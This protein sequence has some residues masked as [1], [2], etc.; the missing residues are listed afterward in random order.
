MNGLTVTGGA[1]LI[2]QRLLVAGDAGGSRSI[3]RY[4]IEEAKR[5]DVRT[6]VQLGDLGY[7][8]LHCIGYIEDVANM[9]RDADM[10]AFF[11][12]G[13]HDRSEHLLSRGA[14]LGQPVNYNLPVQIRP[15]LY[16]LPRGCTW[17]AGGVTFMGMGGAASIDKEERI[18]LEVKDGVQRWWPSEIISF[19]DMQRAIAHRDVDV[20]F[21][22]EYPTGV[23]F[24]RVKVLDTEAHPESVTERNKLRQVVDACGVRAVFHGHHNVRYSDAFQGTRGAVIVNGLADDGPDSY[25]IFDTETYKTRG[26]PNATP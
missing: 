10:W 3:W 8:G 26:E 9:L 15:R 25:T 14:V 5:F 23:D 1:R 24:G 17:K 16:Y 12:D 19:A 20:L 11:I 6:I 2:H 4:W 18:R 7:E 22:H 13:N 21:S